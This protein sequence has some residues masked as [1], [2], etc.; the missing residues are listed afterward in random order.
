MVSSYKV[1]NSSLGHSAFAT[2]S[3]FA[4]LAYSRAS[5]ALSPRCLPRPARAVRPASLA[6]SARH[7]VRHQSLVKV[8]APCSQAWACH[9]KQDHSPRPRRF[10]RSSSRLEA[11][12]PAFGLAA[13]EATMQR[14]A[15]AFKHQAFYRAGQTRSCA[16]LALASVHGSLG[17]QGKEA[18]YSAAA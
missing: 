17:I 8:G 15:N 2:T 13:F 18:G 11:F 3:C 7:S 16:A 6:A 10:C 5:L 4:E 9:A 12:H 1:V 14:H